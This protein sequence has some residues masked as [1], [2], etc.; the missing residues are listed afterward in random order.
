MRRNHKLDHVRLKV[1]GPFAPLGPFRPGPFGKSAQCPLPSHFKV[2][3][4]AY[5]GLPWALSGLG[6]PSQAWGRAL[7][8]KNAPSRTFGC[9]PGLIWSL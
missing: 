4:H 9:P 8:S 2:R 5:A 3:F 7:F 1:Q 6:W